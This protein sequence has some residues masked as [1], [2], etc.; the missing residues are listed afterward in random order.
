MELKVT[1]VPKPN[2]AGFAI[3]VCGSK[4]NIALHFNPRFNCGA[5]QRVIVLNT[6]KD[7]HWQEEVK[8]RNFP[9]QQGK[10]FEVTIIF[11]DDKFYINLHDGHVLLFPNRLAGKQY[12]CIL[13][14]GEVTI[15]GIYV[16]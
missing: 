2:A 13:I 1:G 9:F 7:G 14:D 5:D 8:E 11:A 4:D 3:N 16:K 6:R 15:N 10:E 12:D